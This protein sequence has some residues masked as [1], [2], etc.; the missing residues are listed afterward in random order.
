MFN[1]PPEIIQH[2]WEYDPT[3]HNHFRYKVIP[4]MKRTFKIVRIVVHNALNI[5]TCQQTRRLLIDDL[6]SI[7]HLTKKKESVIGVAFEISNQKRWYGV[8][9]S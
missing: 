2:I 6:T 9:Y 4:E 5:A 8:V 7:A 3:Y 1:L